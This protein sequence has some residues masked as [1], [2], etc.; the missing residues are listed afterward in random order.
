MSV[1]VLT[2]VYGEAPAVLDFGVP[3]LPNPQVERGEGVWSSEFR[4]IDFSKI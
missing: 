3:G 1:R 2:Y 4:C